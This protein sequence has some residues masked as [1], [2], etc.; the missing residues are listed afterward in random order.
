MLFS[1]HARVAACATMLLSII[2]SASGCYWQSVSRA[3]VAS[4][5]GWSSEKRGAGAVIFNTNL[6][7]FIRASNNSPR[8]QS[9]GISFYFD[10]HVTGFELNP[11]KV[12]LALPNQSKVNP[13]SINLV[14]AGPQSRSPQWDCGR[15]P[16]A[17]FGTGP[18]YGVRRGTC[19]EL[20][21]PVAPL[22]P[23]AHFTLQIHG[24]RKDGRPVMMPDIRFELGRTS[25]F[26]L[27][28]FP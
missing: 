15:Y 27:P 2:A 12:T 24:L 23:N 28:V 25:V 17:D 6:S 26:A 8:S 16:P 5:S 11:K 22:S 1:R 21:F 10:P 14:F 7:I 18:W 20:Y 3:Y 9:F 19:V 4:D 13:S